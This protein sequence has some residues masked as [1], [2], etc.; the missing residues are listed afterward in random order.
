M[1]IKQGKARFTM[2]TAVIISVYKNDTLPVLKEAFDSLFKQS[3]QE[4]DIFV[5]IDGDITPDLDIYLDTLYKEKKIHSLYK[6]SENR[7]LAYSLNELIKRV[8]DLK[9]DYIIR[10]DADDICSPERIEHQLDY[11]NKHPEVDLLGGWIEEFNTD[12][13]ER[14]IVY[15]PEHHNDIFNLLAKR[16]PIAHVTAAF[17]SSF[18]HK[19]GLYNVTSQC[20]DLEL[21]VRA[22]KKGAKMHNL[23][24]VLVYVRTNNAF[25]TR[26]RNQKRAL[27]L[28]Q[29]KVAATKQFK[30]GI[31]GYLFATAHYL[32][33]MAPGPIKHFFYKYFR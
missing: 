4:F 9:Y 25:F 11:L 7:G 17:R 33:W 12:T 13:K 20:E 21:W 6:R 8:L 28:W 18:F 23:Q 29:I 5:Q 31:K 24:E 22:F 10:M 1:F 14:R 15:Y 26:R 30:L 2:K 19:Y 3:R 16:S 27:E 32:V